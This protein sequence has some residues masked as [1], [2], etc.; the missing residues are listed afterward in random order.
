MFSLDAADLM[1]QISNH[2]MNHADVA[3]ALF[4]ILQNGMT[5][6][7]GQHLTGLQEIQERL[8]KMRQQSLKQYDIDAVLKDIEKSLNE[9]EG[10]EREGIQQR[11]ND[12]QQ[13]QEDAPLE[14]DD[15][16]L[17]EAFLDNLAHQ[18]E[19]FL[20]SLPSDPSGKVNWLRDYE[21]MDQKAKVKFEE[22]LASLQ[23]LAAEQY[24]QGMS[25]G[26]G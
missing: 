5:G 7:E 14:S 16:E 23:K 12:V 9:I 15:Q 19:E 11:L 25:Q 13:R 17:H 18:N 21:F 4:S 6:R 10:L 26:L 20:D 3:S 22:L 24:F 1:E 2:L 8:R